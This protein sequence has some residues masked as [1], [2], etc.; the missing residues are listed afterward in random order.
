M[1]EVPAILP[2]REALSA[3]PPTHAKIAGVY[4]KTQE[5]ARA[6]RSDQALL[7]PPLNHEVAQ[8]TNVIIG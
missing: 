5:E 1:R 2:A 8:A 4:V 3:T 6:D 7:V